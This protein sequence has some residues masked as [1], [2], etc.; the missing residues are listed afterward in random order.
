MGNAAI[1]PDGGGDRSVRFP[2]RSERR[3][4]SFDE[5]PSIRSADRFGVDWI[6]RTEPRSD[7]AIDSLCEVSDPFAVS[8]F[9]EPPWEVR[10]LGALG[11]YRAREGSDRVPNR[12][13]CKSAHFS[14]GY[15]SRAA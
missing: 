1:D 7:T 8:R 12:G 3:D 14:I 2:R 15:G 10:S 11:D 13:E 4:Y 5:H 6:V 9:C